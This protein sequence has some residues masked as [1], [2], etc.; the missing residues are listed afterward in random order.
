MAPASVTAS[1]AES[2]Q[3][4]GKDFLTRPAEENHIVQFY[5]TEEFLS[6]VVADFLQAGIAAGEPLVVI[7]TEDHRRAF[8]QRLTSRGVD[9]A[10]G[11][12]SGQYTFLDARESL[13]RFMVG[14]MPDWALFSTLIGGV[15]EKSESKGCHARV[16]AYGEMVDL[17]WKDGNPKAAIRLEE[18]WN[19]ISEA[20]SFSLLCAYQMGL[21]ERESDAQP[22]NHVCRAHSHV[23]PAEKYSQI[24]DPDARLR[25]VSALQQRAQA[26]ET[27]IE[28]R[29][30]V[31]SALR[32]ALATRD[33]F[34]SVAGHELRTPLTAIHLHVQ[35]IMGL[36]GE[37]KDTRVR[38]RLGKISRQ[39]GRLASLIEELLD[40]SRIRSGR[41]SLE[42]EEVDLAALVQEAVERAS[43]SSTDLDCSVQV[44][45]ERPVIGTWDRA[46]I[47]QVV[48][49]LLSNAMKYGRG[50]AIE[51]TVTGTTDRS[52]LVV[53]DNGIGIPLE[54]QARIFDRFERAVSSRNFSGLGLGLWIV[55]QIVEAHRG[56][57]H[58]ES[59]VGK[60]A[61]FVVEL[62]YAVP[63]K[64]T[65]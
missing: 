11:C 3:Y 28:A 55:K 7:A 33:D 62:P 60:G 38:D 45:I 24:L 41:L 61:T 31:E 49:N 44:L 54:D 64:L 13:A 40:V 10:A 21:F 52:R 16:R 20:Y 39:V 35:S 58:V 51:V 34:L 17:L 1:E 63:A 65:A 36:A 48:I 4:V 56:T 6:D 29:K 8:I 22:F 53:R 5:E 2:R 57:V 50:N 18:L 14:G 43:E 59:E 9:V 46:R 23:I 37:A 47:E 30:Q 32:E 15:L 12:E 27:E 19:E 25:E 26:L 42:P